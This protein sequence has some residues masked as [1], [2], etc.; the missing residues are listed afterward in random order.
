MSSINKLKPRRES[1]PATE[2]LCDH[3]TAKCCHYIASQIDTPATHEDFDYIRWYIMHANAT[4][5]VEE[6]SWY[7]LVYTTCKHLLPDHRCGV[8][9]TRPQ[10]CRDYS[11]VNCEY[12]DDWVYDRYFET[13]EQVD[14]Y[15]EAVLPAKKGHN[16]RSR[17]PALLPIIG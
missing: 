7:L 6:G 11:T 3:C 1:I 12:E 17:K 15:V 2:N 14:E 13:S 10:I 8:Y 4:V 9:E 16:F 5:F